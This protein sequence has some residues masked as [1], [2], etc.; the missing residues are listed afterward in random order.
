MDVVG[1]GG[2]FLLN[3][4]P[5]PNGELPAEAVQRMKEIGAWMRINGEAIYGSRCIAPYKEGQVVFTR[6]EGAVY[7]ICL[8]NQKKED[9]PERVT[10]TALKPAPK[11]KLQLLG[12]R[13]PLAWTTAADGTTTIEIPTAIRQ[14]PPCSH[15]FAFRFTQAQ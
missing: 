11:S 6:K 1:K 12:V 4:G 7:A 3:V 14:A 9:L 8:T 15:A 13:K 5:Q 10:F 2:N